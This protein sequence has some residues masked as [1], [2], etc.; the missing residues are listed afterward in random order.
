MRPG[1]GHDGTLRD[2]PVSRALVGPHRLLRPVRAPVAGPAFADSG[3]P[4]NP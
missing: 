4:G 1:R 3:E 2:D